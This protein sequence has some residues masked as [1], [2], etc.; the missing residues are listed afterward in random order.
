MAHLRLKGLR[1]GMAALLAA[2][3]AIW[4]GPGVGQAQQTSLTV[5]T[6]IEADDLK[7]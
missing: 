7:K 2:L 6:A 1:V 3:G 5:Y 4:P